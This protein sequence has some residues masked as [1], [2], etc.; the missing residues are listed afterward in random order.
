[1]TGSIYK[2]LDCTE[3][4]YPILIGLFSTIE[5]ANEAINDGIDPD[6][7]EPPHYSYHDFEE[8]VLQIVEVKTER[9]YNSGFEQTLVQTRKWEQRYNEESDQYYWEEVSNVQ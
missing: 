9:I 2:L 1:M 3:E 7:K 4:D 6:T 8:V 5:A